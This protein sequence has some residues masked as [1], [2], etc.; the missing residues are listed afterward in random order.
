MRSVHDALAASAITHHQQ[1]HDV[2]IVINHS[3]LIYCHLHERL[4]RHVWGLMWSHALIVRSVAASDNNDGD[5]DT[6]AEH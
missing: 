2:T 1:Q 6:C 4:L 5:A 3:R